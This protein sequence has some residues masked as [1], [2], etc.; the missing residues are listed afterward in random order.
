MSQTTTTIATTTATEAAGSSSTDTLPGLEA[1]NRLESLD[2]MELLTRKALALHLRSLGIDFTSLALEGVFDLF[3]LYMN[4]TLADL[5]KIVQVQR[6]FKASPK[7]L[8]ILLREHGIPMHELENELIRSKRIPNDLIKKK[9]ELN[10]IATEIARV[11]NNKHTTTEQEEEE[12]ED[13]DHEDPSYAFFAH[14]EGLS[15]LIPSAHKRGKKIPSWLPQFPPDHTYLKTP[16]YTNRITDPKVVRTKIAEESR[17]GEK[18]LDNLISFETKAEHHHD[19][20]NNLMNNVPVDGTET[21][22]IKLEEDEKSILW[23]SGTEKTLDIVKYSNARLKFLERKKRQAALKE[24]KLDHKYFKIISH[25]SSYTS[26]EK[27]NSDLEVKPQGYIEN[28]FNIALNSLI[29][30]KKQKNQRDVE[31]VE[32]QKQED[33]KR[34]QIKLTQKKDKLDK[35]NGNGDDDDAALFNEFENFE[36]FDSF[37]FQ[38]IDKSENNNDNSND[39]NNIITIETNGIDN[40]E[41]TND[42]DDVPQDTNEDDDDEMIDFAQFEAIEQDQNFDDFEESESNAGGTPPVT[43]QFSELDGGD[44][45]ETTEQTPMS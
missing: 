1:V 34:E 41:A 35:T 31:R 43:V 40:N 19:D 33:L 6:R 23:V 10:E 26:S 2:E 30:L 37:D 15:N 9:L 36:N 39:N 22:Q 45:A 29:S 17:F 20:V 11:R 18:A 7:D 38:N 21:N 32:L 42:G 25:L 4:S 24:S 14:N 28:Q 8:R 12:Q 5:S 13:V 44:T 3:T 27:Y 16:N